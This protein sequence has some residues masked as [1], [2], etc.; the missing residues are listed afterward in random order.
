MKH[1]AVIVLLFVH[2]QVSSQLYNSYFTGNSTDV[3]STSQ[4]G[5]CMMGGASE[6][7]EAMKWFLERADGGDILVLRASGSDGYNDYLYSDLGIT[8]NSVETI[9]FNNP[10][11]AW[12]SN[13][14]FRSICHRSQSKCSGKN[15]SQSIEGC[16]LHRI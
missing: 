13:R 9:V 8:V 12:V 16:F 15:T 3:T 4:G 1:L 5:V 6:H 2:V 14:L 11:A 10:N 7:N